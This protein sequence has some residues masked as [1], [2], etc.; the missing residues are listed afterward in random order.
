MAEEGDCVLNV[1]ALQLGTSN[2]LSTSTVL[3]HL[4]RVMKERDT[5][6]NCLYEMSSERVRLLNFIQ[7]FSDFCIYFQT[8]GTMTASL[9]CVTYHIPDKLSS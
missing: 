4:E 2:N 8:A 7:Q 1:E 3:A 9:S 5:Y 6:A